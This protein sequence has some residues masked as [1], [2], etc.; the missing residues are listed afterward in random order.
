[1][2]QALRLSGHL[3][4]KSDC[5]RSWKAVQQGKCLVGTLARD[6]IA[7]AYAIH[8]ASATLESQRIRLQHR[9]GLPNYSIWSGKRIGNSIFFTAN[10]LSEMTG[11]WRNSSPQHIR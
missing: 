7:G 1:M 2:H 6:R 8:C 11:P 10:D 3:W 5:S 9:Y 4:T